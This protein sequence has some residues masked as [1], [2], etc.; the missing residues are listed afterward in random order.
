MSVN[1]KPKP[2]EAAIAFKTLVDEM[3]A[4]QPDIFK[5]PRLWQ[6]LKRGS[7]NLIHTIIHTIIAKAK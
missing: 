2:Q 5:R 4:Q 3:K 1:T 7:N 6:R